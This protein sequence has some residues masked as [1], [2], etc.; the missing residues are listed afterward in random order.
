MLNPITN[1]LDNAKLSMLSGLKQHFRYKFQWEEQGMIMISTAPTLHIRGEG[2]FSDKSQVK[3]HLY[4]LTLPNQP[5]IIYSFIFY[6]S[7]YEYAHDEK[8][9]MTILNSLRPY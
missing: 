7:A 8:I 5:T 3:F 1:T 2:S 4:L 6:L 9:M